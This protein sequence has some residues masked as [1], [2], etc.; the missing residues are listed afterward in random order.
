[1]HHHLDLWMALDISRDSRPCQ[2][3]DLCNAGVV[4]AVLDS[5]S[6]SVAGGAGDDYFHERTAG[7]PP[8]L[9]ASAAEYK[10]ERNELVAVRVVGGVQPVERA[11]RWRVSSYTSW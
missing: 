11:T 2:D 4:N 5:L 9:L 7:R 1:V 10:E 3:D 8:G 6:A